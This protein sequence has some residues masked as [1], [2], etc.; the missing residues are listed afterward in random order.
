MILD[1]A[2]I[3]SSGL[4]PLPWLSTT[5]AMILVDSHLNKIQW[6]SDNLCH[7]ALE[8]LPHAQSWIP[9][10][11]CLSSE[12]PTGDKGT[13]ARATGSHGYMY[14]STDFSDV[15]NQDP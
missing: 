10:Y 9:G 12:L 8:N 6:F 14:V 1:V 2:N 3:E 5:L 13:P 7:E 11:D 4:Y 15:V